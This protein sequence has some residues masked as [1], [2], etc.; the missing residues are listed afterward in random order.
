MERWPR[1]VTAQ[2]ERLHSPDRRARSDAGRAE[3]AAG[4]LGGLHAAVQAVRLQRQGP[5]LQ[6]QNAGQLPWLR[7]FGKPL[8]WQINYQISPYQNI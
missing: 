8:R 2:S 3:H 7:R 4:D 1:P 6:S 5:P